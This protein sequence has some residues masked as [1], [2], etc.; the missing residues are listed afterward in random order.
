MR[1]I[2]FPGEKQQIT[3]KKQ[4]IKKSKDNYQVPN[5][6]RMRLIEMTQ[7]EGI[8]IYKARKMLDLKYSTAKQIVKL[9]KQTGK[10]ERTNQI[11]RGR[12]KQESDEAKVEDIQ[13]ITPLTSETKE[14]EQVS[15]A[16]GEDVTGVENFLALPVRPEDLLC[17][18]LDRNFSIQEE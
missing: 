15:K 1:N 10:I 16:S 8:S 2:T 17:T 3:P 12:K 4:K 9:Y 13:L 11:K 5:E 18:D 6:I 14:D 7:S